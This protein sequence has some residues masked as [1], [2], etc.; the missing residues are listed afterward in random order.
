M[1]RVLVNIMSDLHCEL[2]STL[3]DAR[4]DQDTQDS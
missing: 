3:G 4:L 2:L 1:Q